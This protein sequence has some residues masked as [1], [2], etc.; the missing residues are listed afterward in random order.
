MAIRV[1]LLTDC[2]IFAAFIKEPADKNFTSL[3]MAEFTGNCH[4][5]QPTGISW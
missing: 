5:K 4:F 2:E 1:P 3:V